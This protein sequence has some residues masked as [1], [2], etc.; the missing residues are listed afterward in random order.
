MPQVRTSCAFKGLTRDQRLSKNAVRRQPLPFTRLQGQTISPSCPCV[1]I[2]AYPLN[3]AVRHMPHAVTKPP[4]LKPGVLRSTTFRIRRDE[5]RR[6]AAYAAQAIKDAARP[7]ITALAAPFPLSYI[8]LPSPRPGEVP[9]DTLLGALI[10]VPTAL[11]ATY[12]FISILLSATMFFFNSP[13]KTQ[14]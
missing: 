11:G 5:P 13:P 1:I 7:T 6:P 4:S 14:K 10:A 2:S 3:K 8:R 9:H 12:S